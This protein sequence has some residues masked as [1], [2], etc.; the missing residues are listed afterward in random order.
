MFIVGT[1]VFT[2]SGWKAIETIG[3]RDKVLIRNFI[4]DAEFIQPFAVKRRK[5]NGNILK[6]GGKHWSFSV[7]P[8]HT[9]VYDR[10]DTPIGANFTYIPAKS[11]KI[12]KNNRIYRKFKFLAPDEF[13]PE[14]ISIY[15]EFGK[16]WVT[17]SNTDWFTLVGYVLCRGKI[18]KLKTRHALRIALDTEKPEELRLLTDILDRTGVVYSVYPDAIRVNGQNSLATRLANFLGSKKRK[19]MFLPDKMIY[20]SSRQL[21]ETLIEAIINAS[22]SPNTKRRN[23]Y[24]L[25]TTN[26]K[27]IDSLILFGTLYGYGMSFITTIPEGTETAYTTVKNDVYALIISNPT[28]TYSPSFINKEP[29]EGY[30]YGFNIFEGQVYV[31]EEK[32]PVWVNPK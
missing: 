11:L 28:K 32:M 20:N 4:G 5:H 22:I 16:R 12:H 13:K 18:E 10:D 31:K 24:R 14:K 1:K 17:I 3:G 9:I 30:T 6:I 7:T 8:D 19:E 25:T 29:Y 23:E 15:D 2:D 21:A 27:L 26:K